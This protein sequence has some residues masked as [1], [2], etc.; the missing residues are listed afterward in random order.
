MPVKTS[1]DKYIHKINS[2]SIESFHRIHEILELSDTII[3]ENPGCHFVSEELLHYN[4][5]FEFSRIGR[6]PDNVTFIARDMI[7]NF[8]LRSFGIT[9]VLADQQNGVFLAWELSKGLGINI[10]F[11][12]KESTE[13]DKILVVSGVI[14]NSRRIKNLVKAVEINGDE[15]AGV[16]GF[17][18]CSGID[19]DLLNLGVPQ[20]KLF[21]AL[22]MKNIGVYTGD[23]CP[24]CRKGSETQQ[25]IDF[26]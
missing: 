14:L 24:Y 13:K 8:S 18:N 26:S 11:D 16:L 21:I 22:E 23:K 17:A 1:V 6:T 5:V 9:R 19:K 4:A 25:Y 10:A 2:V 12:I 15:V 7:E 20:K 3:F